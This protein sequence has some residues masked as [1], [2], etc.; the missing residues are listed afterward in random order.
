MWLPHRVKGPCWEGILAR[1]LLAH[2]PPGC[3]DL[4]TKCEACQ[5]HSKKLHQPAQALQT[6]PLSWPFSVWG[7]DILGPFPRAVGGFEYLYVAIDKFTKWLEV[8]VVRKVKTQ[9][10]VK[11]FKGLVCRFGVPNRVIT[12]NGTQFTSRTFMQYIHDLVSKVCFASMAH[13][14]SNGQVERS[15][16]EVLRGLRMKTFDRL[17]KSGRR[18]IDELPRFFGRSERRQIEPPARHP[19][20]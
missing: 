8:E 14:R 3:D 5:F 2:R 9:S 4:V 15:N 6:I 11:F 13:P 20:P 16:A 19:L 17:R 12:D 18:W 7:L 10:A 1:F